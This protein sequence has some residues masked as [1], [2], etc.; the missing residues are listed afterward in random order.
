MLKQRFDLWIIA[1]FPFCIPSEVQIFDERSNVRVDVL[2]M[3][4]VCAIRGDILHVAVD[5]MLCLS[6]I[7]EC[8]DETA[9][10]YH[11]VG[12]LLEE[13]LDSMDPNIDISIHLFNWIF[14][15]SYFLGFAFFPG[16]LAIFLAEIVVI[17]H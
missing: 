14:P 1:C 13:L 9:N 3:G 4:D 7:G 8:V 6:A 11:G 2:E 5:V 16:Q 15:Q 12:W 10:I 17:L